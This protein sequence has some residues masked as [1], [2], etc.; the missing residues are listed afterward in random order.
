MA[1]PTLST[2]FA[3]CVI[4]LDRLLKNVYLIDERLL[5]TDVTERFMARFRK[6]LT[7]TIVA[8][9]LTS[10]AVFARE[11]KPKVI[12]FDVNETLLDLAPLKLSVGKALNGREDLLPLWFSTMLHYSLVETV[13]DNYRSFGE[14]GTAALMMVAE[15]QGLEL[16]YDEAKA[17]VVT[18]LRSLP[19]H[20]DVVAGL[21]AL[22]ADGYRL[23]SLTN[24]SAA[25]VETQ[26][27]NAD[28][29]HFFEKRY[30]VDSTRKFKPHPDT[31]RFVLQDLGVEPDEALMVAAHAWD[32][33]GAKSVGMRT[34]FVA[35]P[36]KVLYPNAAKPDYVISDLSDLSGKL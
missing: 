15:A 17:A 14:I 13:T 21:S 32:L 31:Y 3:I 33:A 35:R 19:P 24:S 12:I 4:E 10:G 29:T 26:F 2:L 18:P 6:M 11:S 28:L 34:A 36:G 9:G 20:P 30:T 23:V 27:K 16:G 25:G 5:K 22:K 8:L 7:L 1:G